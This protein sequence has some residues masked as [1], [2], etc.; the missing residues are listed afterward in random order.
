MRALL[1]LLVC[2]TAV[3][4]GV[5]TSF[6]ASRNRARGGELDQRQH[7]CEALE[8]QIELLRARNAHEEW[9]LLSGDA[10]EDATPWSGTRVE[11][12]Q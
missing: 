5:R 1:A 8:R 2:A 10:E 7:R 4:A 9:L 6:L 12:E 3:A 11:V